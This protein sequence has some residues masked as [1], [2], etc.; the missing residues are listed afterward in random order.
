ME[1]T[2]YRWKKKLK[3]NINNSETPLPEKPKKEMTIQ[4]NTMDKTGEAAGQV[5][6]NGCDKP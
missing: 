2:E 4:V 3:N 1:N 6:Q 5:S